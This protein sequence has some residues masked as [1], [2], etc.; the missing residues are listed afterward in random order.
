MRKYDIDF[1]D[2][3]KRLWGDLQN[4]EKLNAPRTKLVLENRFNDSVIEKS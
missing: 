1:I 4:R 3:V 2:E